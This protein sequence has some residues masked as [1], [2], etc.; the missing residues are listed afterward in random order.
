VGGG[1]GL[2]ILLVVGLVNQPKKD[3]KVE[4]TAG[5]SA[6]PAPSAALSSRTTTTLITPSTVAATT[7]AP[8]T[9]AAPATT[10]PVPGSLSALE[11]LARIPV[12]KEVQA[13]YKRDLF[14][15]WDDADHD[16][17]DSRA[18]VL[19]RDSTVPAPVSSGC[20]APGWWM[21]A[22]DGVVVTDASELQVDHVVALQEAW[23]SGAYAWSP[24]RRIAYGNDL[25]DRRTLRAVTVA[26]NEAK[27]DKDPSNWLPPLEVDQCSYIGDV[28]AIKARWGLS[29]DQSEWGRIR[30]LLAG[31]CAGWTIAPWAAPPVPIQPPTTPATTAAP[32][33][34]P[35]P[36]P[37]PSP[38]PTPAATPAPVVLDP[39]FGTCKEAKAN[40]YGPYHQG[41]DPE[42]DWYRDADSDG[43]VC[44]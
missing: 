27:G 23:D 37:A 22:Y 12:A 9:T 8:P 7:S 29:M 30:I 35:P 21:S 19:I 6:T 5:P 40:G 43:I 20:T 3:T 32:K 24:A 26:S 25:T 31:P 16:G 41:V 34:T 2:G 4:T 44:E 38:A 1:A 14:G 36:T 17:C 18:E 10:R 11:V 39:Q 42:Y 28:V 13:G 15:V 33:A